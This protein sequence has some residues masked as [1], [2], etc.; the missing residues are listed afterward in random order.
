MVIIAF[1]ARTSDVGVRPFSSQVQV[2]ST[3][4]E[5]VS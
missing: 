5:S 2:N 4:T 1:L 3:C